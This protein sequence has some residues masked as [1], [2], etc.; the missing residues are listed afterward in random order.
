MNR[1][2]FQEYL[3][4]KGIQSSSLETYKVIESFITD[5]SK[6]IMKNA[7][8][9]ALRLPSSTPGVHAIHLDVVTKIMKSLEKSQKQGHKHSGGSKCSSCG[10]A[11]LPVSYFSGGRQV[12]PALYYGGAESSLPF[13]Y[14]SGGALSV[15]L[16]IEDTY[17]LLKK[18]KTLKDDSIKIVQKFINSS[19]SALFHHIAQ[20]KSKRDANLDAKLLRSTIEILYPY[21][22]G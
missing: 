1:T 17:K 12:L 4:T 15:L 7:A 10:G 19:I 18:Y 20:G 21:I 14:F 2:R 3:A 22:V 6:K 11:V 5:L 8:T 16:S 13:S 9:V